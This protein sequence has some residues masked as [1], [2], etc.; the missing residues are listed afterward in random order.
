[1]SGGVKDSYRI[2]FTIYDDV[3]LLCPAGVDERQRDGVSG[4]GGLLQGFQ[5]NRVRRQRREC[6]PL[7]APT[8]ANHATQRSRYEE[9][10]R[11][12]IR[13]R[14]HLKLNAGMCGFYFTFLR[15]SVVFN[16]ALIS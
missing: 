5:R 15:I 8:R 11:N 6:A 16:F 4:C 12:L 7:D 3:I 14:V 13:E 9:P 2:T 10:L 1:M